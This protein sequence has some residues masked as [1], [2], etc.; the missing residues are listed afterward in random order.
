MA[1]YLESLYPILHE[2]YSER[3]RELLTHA[4]LDI[5]RPTKFSK[6]TMYL[7]YINE[8]TRQSLNIDDVLC[9]YLIDVAEHVIVN[10]YKMVACFVQMFRLCMNQNGFEL[11]TGILPFDDPN[12][13]STAGAKAPATLH[14]HIKELITKKEA[15]FTQ[16]SSLSII[17]QFAEVFLR[18]FLPQKCNIFPEKH[19]L[20]LFEHL[21]VW[22]QNRKFLKQHTISRVRGDG[23][24]PGTAP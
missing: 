18:K 21:L 10:F 3:V 20:I 1:E 14:Q 19:A 24:R 9:L 22:L 6:G 17:P 2:L 23:G 15:L 4:G 5:S 13:S 8:E 16:K 12:Q 7:I 11:V